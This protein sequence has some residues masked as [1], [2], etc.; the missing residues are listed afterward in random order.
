MVNSSTPRLSLFFTIQESKGRTLS[1]SIDSKTLI[2]VTIKAMTILREP[3]LPWHDLQALL[4]E[5]ALGVGGLE[6]QPHYIRELYLLRLA[7]S[8]KS[9]PKLNRVFSQT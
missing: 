1:W 4:L 5:S 2:I 6:I 8:S 7:T 3:V 9:A